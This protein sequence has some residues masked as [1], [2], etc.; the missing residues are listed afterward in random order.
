MGT[1]IT[2]ERQAEM[3]AAILEEQLREAIRA[4]IAPLVERIERLTERLVAQTRRSFDNRFWLAL[5]GDLM[6][7]HWRRQAEQ[8]NPA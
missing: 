2:P 3:E 1:R 4:E 7:D 6:V 5:E 8:G